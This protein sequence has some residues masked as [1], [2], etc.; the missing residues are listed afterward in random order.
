MS[1]SELPEAAVGSELA[2]GREQVALVEGAGS[3]QATVEA[4]AAEVS[5][6]GRRKRKN[7]EYPTL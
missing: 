5:P 4:E 3:E 2:K 6:Q 7:K 1:A